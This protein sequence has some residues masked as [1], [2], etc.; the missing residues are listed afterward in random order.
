VK[1]GLATDVFIFSPRD[2]EANAAVEPGQQ[3]LAAIHNWLPR[4]GTERLGEA[5]STGRFG[6]RLAKA[7]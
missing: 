1:G 2:S 5:A 7:G 6:V 3:L 4:S